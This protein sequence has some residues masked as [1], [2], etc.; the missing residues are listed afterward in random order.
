MPVKPP[1]HFAR[2]QIASV[3]GPL[4]NELVEERAATLGRLTRIFEEALAAYRSA[5]IDDAGEAYR[6]RLCQAAAEA[7]WHFVIQREV[8]GFRNT[9]SV[10]REYDVPSAV[11]FRMGVLRR[12]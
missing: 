2:R 11:R 3:T 7:L 9:E 8:C 4:E 12:G 5:L 10:L 6:E 1:S